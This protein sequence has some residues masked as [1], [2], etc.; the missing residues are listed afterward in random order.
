MTRVAVAVLALV[1]CALWTGCKPRTDAPLYDNLGS[2]HHAVTASAGAQKYFDQGLRLMY[3]FNH[4]E[5]IASFKEG[6]RLDPACGM[7]WWG[8][9]VAL[10][11]NI[12]LPMDPA[13]GPEAWN[14]LEK[15]TALAPRL[16]PSE[17]DYI[18]ALSQRYAANPPDNRAPLDS[19][20]ARAMGD[21]AARH[22]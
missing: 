21:L 11:P 17:R 14:A 4:D 9:A 13:A 10:G 20:Y 5:A 6:A 3:G 7:C 2:L 12:N 15:A 19:A 16:T 8:V 18:A 22:P 1:G